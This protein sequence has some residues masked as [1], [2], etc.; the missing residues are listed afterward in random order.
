MPACA[1]EVSFCGAATTASA[2]PPIAASTAAA[3]NAIEARPAIG[4]TMPNGERSR[5]RL[6]AGQDI[7]SAGLD[8]DAAGLGVA[9]EQ[10]RIA[11]QNWVADRAAPQDRAPSCSAISGPMPAGSPVGMAILILPL[12]SALAS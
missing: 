11:D 4:L 8:P 3:K 12:I 7:D 1:I 2:S 9:H 6:L 5:V 10:V